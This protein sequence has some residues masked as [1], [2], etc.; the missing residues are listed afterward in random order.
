MKHPVYVNIDYYNQNNSKTNTDRYT[1]QKSTE[2]GKKN[3]T[4]TDLVP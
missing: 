3:R 2:K 1:K 4:T